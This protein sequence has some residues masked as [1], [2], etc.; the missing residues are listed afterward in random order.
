[1]EHLKTLLLSGGSS[2]LPSSVASRS[3]EPDFAAELVQG[4]EEERDELRLR[5]A[6]LSHVVKQLETEN[7]ELRA[8]I[9]TLRE[10][11]P[12]SADDEPK[13]VYRL[14]LVLLNGIVLFSPVVY[15]LFIHVTILSVGYLC[16]S[17]YNT[18]HNDQMGSDNDF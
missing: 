15:Y 8:T 3:V 17:V 9:S 1:V 2:Q 13:V 12:R 4:V 7:G 11:Q 5:Q 10:G 14:C 18:V 16:V 6:E